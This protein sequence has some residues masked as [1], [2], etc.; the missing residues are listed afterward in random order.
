MS[1][2]LSAGRVRSAYEFI[3]AYRDQYSVHAMWHVRGGE[4]PAT[5]NLVRRATRN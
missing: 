4:F 1:T 5:A 3:K 2:R